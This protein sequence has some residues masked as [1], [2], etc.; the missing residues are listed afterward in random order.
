MFGGCR[1]GWQCKIGSPGHRCQGDVAGDRRP[2][3]DSVR[4][5][6]DYWAHAHPLGIGVVKNHSE[7]AVS[8]KLGL[9]AFS[10][11]GLH[12]ILDQISKKLPG[13]FGS[14]SEETRPACR[15]SRSLPP[16]QLGERPRKRCGN[17]L[18]GFSENWSVD[19]T[20]LLGSRRGQCGTRWPAKDTRTAGKGKFVV[21]ILIAP[22]QRVLESR[23][24]RQL[25][26]RHDWTAAG[27]P[28]VGPTQHQDRIQ[29]RRSPKKR[30]GWPG[31]VQP[32]QRNTSC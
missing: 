28:T 25:R 22:S 5:W 14:P 29:G 19:T 18:L 11:A 30:A 24:P 1:P 7:L 3:S 32:T 27:R 26:E 6:A 13:W 4:C 31:H 15:G 9:P 21:G 20:I 8:S 17:G 23:R 16:E 10:R 2:G 12:V